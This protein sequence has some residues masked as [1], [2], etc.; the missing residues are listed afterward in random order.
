MD[1]KRASASF[2]AD[3]DMIKNHIEK[4]HKSFKYVN[5]TVENALYGEVLR[6]LEGHRCEQVPELSHKE[7]AR[8]YKTQSFGFYLGLNR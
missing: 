2:K 1:A 4:M 6:Y 8:R 7:Q 3:E 5:E